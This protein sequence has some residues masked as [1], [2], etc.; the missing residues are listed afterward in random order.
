MEFRR[1]FLIITTSIIFLLFTSCW[2]IGPQ[3][4]LN[5][6]ASDK[7]DMYMRLSNR[8]M[9]ILQ[10]VSIN[11]LIIDFEYVNGL[12][13]I[14][15]TEIEFKRNEMEIELSGHNLPNFNYL[16]NFHFHESYG[17]KRVFSKLHTDDMK[18]TNSDR[19]SVSFGKNLNEDTFNLILSEYENGNDIFSIYFNYY[20]FTED[21]KINIIIQENIKMEVG[22]EYRTIFP[23]LIMI[24]FPFLIPF[25]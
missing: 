13:K 5:N 14:G 8:K 1:I 2:S 6:V 10:T 22:V 19:I 15:N 7:S 18:E 3:Y 17:R 20:L 4:K 12:V 11:S 24:L 9:D 23:Y 16:P 21:E 25:Q